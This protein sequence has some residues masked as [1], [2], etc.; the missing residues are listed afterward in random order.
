MQ[1][2]REIARTLTDQLK[3][4]SSHWSIEAENAFH[5]LKQALFLVPVLALPDFSQPFI[6]ETDALGHGVGVVLMQHQRPITFFN[7]VIGILL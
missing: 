2:Y 1:G 6:L 3:K 5:Q 7:Q 4:D